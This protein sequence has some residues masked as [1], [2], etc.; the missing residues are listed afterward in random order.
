MLYLTI[1]PM[2]RLSLQFKF[3]DINSASGVRTEYSMYHKSLA[4]TK[5]SKLQ[6]PLH[7]SYVSQTCGQ[8]QELKYDQ[9]CS[10]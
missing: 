7:I 4:C 2:F 3:A 10:S 9:T 8:A 5:I 1:L 6:F